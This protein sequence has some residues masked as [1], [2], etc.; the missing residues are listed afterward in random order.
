LLGEIGT[1][2]EVLEMPQQEMAFLKYK[3]RDVLVPLN[4]QF[5]QSVDEGNRRVM[6]DLP[7]GL[8]D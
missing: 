8:L 1:I 2:D 6:V 4:E 3:G 7:D 5:I